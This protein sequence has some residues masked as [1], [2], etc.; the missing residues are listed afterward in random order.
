MSES[1]ADEVPAAEPVVLTLHQVASWIGTGANE[2]VTA[3]E[4]TD[5][6]GEEGLGRVAG[7]LGKGPAEAAAYLADR[8]PRVTDAATP[9]GSMTRV[10]RQGTVG[11]DVLLVLFSE[12]PDEVEL[13]E[14]PEGL[15]FGIDPLPSGQAPVLNLR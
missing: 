4:I 7:A 12:V 10:L 1:Q 5:A 2:P 11:D 8:L 9:D 15:S 3:A 6:L 14:P 13:A